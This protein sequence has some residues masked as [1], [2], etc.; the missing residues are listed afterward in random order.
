[1]EKECPEILNEY[2][3]INDDNMDN[4]L[5]EIERL[6]ENIQKMQ[7]KHN[8]EEILER[9]YHERPE[10]YQAELE[11]QTVR[12]LYSKAYFSGNDIYVGDCLTDWCIAKH[13]SPNEKI[14]LLMYSFLGSVV[15]ITN[16]SKNNNDL[17]NKMD[18]NKE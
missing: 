13:F 17:G 6:T 1:M 8:S 10:F 15:N 18:C 12:Q 3:V 16:N 14:R 9:I 11:Y 4:T 2:N 5:D 7:I